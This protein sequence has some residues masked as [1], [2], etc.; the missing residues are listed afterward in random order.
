MI[1]KRKIRNIVDEYFMYF[2]EIGV[3]DDGKVSVGGAV[4]LRPE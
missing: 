2:G 1:D 4:R 3:A